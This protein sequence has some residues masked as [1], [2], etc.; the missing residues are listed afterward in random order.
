MG[1]APCVGAGLARPA[2]AAGCPQM[3]SAPQGG[4]PL[5][6]P[7][8][9]TGPVEGRPLIRH[10][11]A[12]PPSPQR[13]KGFPGSWKPPLRDV[14]GLCAGAGL[15]CPASAAGC[16]QMDSALRGGTPL[17]NPVTETGPVEGRPL[18]R[19]GFAVPPS[20]LWGEGLRWG[21]GICRDTFPLRKGVWELLWGPSRA[22]SRRKL[23]PLPDGEHD[24]EHIHPIVVLYERAPLLHPDAPSY[25]LGCKVAVPDDGEYLLKFQG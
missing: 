5:T 23:F 20:P 1:P 15:A 10:S 21:H 16:P 19:H 9:E 17:T 3:D 25:S 2:S 14:F 22:S 7:V 12:V 6:N 4:T 11:F 24:V 18:I 13:G 8:T